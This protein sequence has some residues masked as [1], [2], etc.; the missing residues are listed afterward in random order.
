M[1]IWPV[2]SGVAWRT[3]KNVI[4]TPSLV[5]PSL[6]FPLLFFIAFAGGLLS[7]L[8]GT[9]A[10]AI[11]AL[12]TDPAIRAGLAMRHRHHAP[13]NAAPSRAPIRQ[14]S[15]ARQVPSTAAGRSI[16]LGENA[17]DLVSGGVQGVQR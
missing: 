12:A 7:T 15:T 5:I 6:M 8:V 11:Y 10:G 17:G 1:N 4:T 2:A 13:A 9:I 3:L 16:G 14:R